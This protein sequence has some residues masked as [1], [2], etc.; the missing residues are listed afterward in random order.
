MAA[1]L[2]GRFIPM[3]FNTILFII[4]GYVKDAVDYAALPATFPEL[5]ERVRFA[6]MVTPATLI[7]IEYCYM[8]WGTY[9]DR[10]EYPY[11]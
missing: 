2:S 5:V 8:C 4:C 10:T 11:T 7:G 1:V 6:A 9:D 3:T